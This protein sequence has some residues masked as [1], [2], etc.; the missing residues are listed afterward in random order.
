[1]SF[2][3]ASHHCITELEFVSADDIRNEVT[4]RSASH[5]QP[6]G[7]HTTILNVLTGETSCSCF[8]A[9]HGECWHETLAMAKFHSLPA[10]GLAYAYTS[11]QLLTA[12]HKAA[13]MLR[14]TRR[15]TW[16]VL[17]ADQLALVCVRA[18]WH[19]RRLLEHIEATTNAVVA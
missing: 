13:N 19:H 11:A 8:G 4:F 17:P 15:R 18:V 9:K 1:M 10:Y 2:V 14:V 3:T 12:G 16:R 6:G 7:F 5:S